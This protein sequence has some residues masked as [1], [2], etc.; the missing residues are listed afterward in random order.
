MQMESMLYVHTKSKKFNDGLNAIDYP[1]VG[2]GI[3]TRRSTVV[4][5][6]LRQVT[7]GCLVP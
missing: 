6:L 5:I 7:T 1:K 4:R 2:K 3:R